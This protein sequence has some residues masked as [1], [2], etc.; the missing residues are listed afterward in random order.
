MAKSHQCTKCGA[1]RPPTTGR[2]EPCEKCG[3]A[4]R[5]HGKRTQS[6][7]PTGRPPRRTNIGATEQM[8]RERRAYLD[9][10]VARI[11][12]EALANIARSPRPGAIVVPAG[13]PMIPRGR[14]N[15]NFGSNAR[16]AQYD[17]KYRSM[18]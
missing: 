7:T 9:S 13:D 11:H 1:T 2:P 3:G 14:G 6:Y 8:L 5:A 10:F 17:R 12:A 4:V 16:T 15:A 18:T